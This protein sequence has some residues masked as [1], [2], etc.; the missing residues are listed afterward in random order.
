MNSSYV[1]LAGAVSAFFLGLAVVAAAFASTS[2]NRAGVNRSLTAITRIYATKTDEPA[3]PSGLSHQAARL[4]RVATTQRSLRWLR[5]WLD[6]AG[7]PPAW[8]VDRI[9]E[10]KGL[11][12]LAVGVLGAMI[13]FAAGSV[14]GAIILA[15]G[16]AVLGFFIPDMIVYEI[17]YHR[18]ETVRR[19]LPDILDTLTVSVE[20]GLGFDAALAYVVRHGKGPLQGEFAR[21]LQEVQLG[22]SRTDALRM[23]ATRTRVIELKTF[24]AIVVQASELGVPIANVLREQSREMRIRRRQ[25]AEEMAQKV[26]VKIVFPLVLCIFP[27][28]LI[29]VLGPGVLRIAQ[30]LL[31]R[32]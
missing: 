30:A 21:V 17:G 9:F 13:G 6:Y 3:P 25:R 1:L 4:G 18:Q 26:G 15:I 28:I 8:S 27:M 16:G 12:L 22:L 23:L 24:C 31:M 19:N 20:A 10:L 7:N 11:V 29:I 14:L 32:H 5:R 2:L